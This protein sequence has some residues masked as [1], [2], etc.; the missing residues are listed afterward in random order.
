M[1]HTPRRIQTTE[2]S[3][4]FV[5]SSSL[6]WSRGEAEGAT[7]GLP[8]SGG[9]AVL[10]TLGVAASVIDDESAAMSEIA[11]ARTSNRSV[12]GTM[13]DYVIVMEAGTGL[14]AEELLNVS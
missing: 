2:S 3:A 6:K 10:L 9:T 4:G 14:E 11:Y 12:L 8:R 7:K 13:T 5:V 1:S